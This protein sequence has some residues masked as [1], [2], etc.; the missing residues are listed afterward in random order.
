MNIRIGLARIV[1]LAACVLLPQAHAQSVSQAPAAATDA[2]AAADAS[3]P[4]QSWLAC[5]RMWQWAGAQCAGLKDAWH[6]GSPTLYLSGYTWHDPGTYSKE[7]LEEFND[8]AWGGGF[9]WSKDA[10]NGDNYGWYA[11][12]FRDSH[13]KYT[14]AIGWSYVT[15]WPP[16]NDVALGVGYTAFFASRPDIANNWPFP[17]ALPL[18]AIK[19]HRVELL[20]TF[21]PKLNAGINHGDVA[22]FFGRY[23]F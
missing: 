16:T 23:R 18:A 22:Y 20:G 3:T 13:Y 19:I 14:K 5:D 4:R 17:A 21:I 15:Y 10:A 6:D 2:D 9:G 12:V 1:I 8:R 11:L 7:K